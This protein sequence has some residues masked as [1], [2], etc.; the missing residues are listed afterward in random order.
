[1]HADLVKHL[2]TTGKKLVL[3]PDADVSDLGTESESETEME[4][5]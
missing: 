2:K 5:F 3:Y 1:M 4:N